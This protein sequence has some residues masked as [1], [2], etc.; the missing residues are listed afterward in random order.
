[1]A[2]HTGIRGPGHLSRV[3][4]A[5]GGGVQPLTLNLPQTGTTYAALDVSGVPSGNVVTFDLIADTYVRLTY[6]YEG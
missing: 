4:A 3:F 2:M 5:T 6:L 1:M